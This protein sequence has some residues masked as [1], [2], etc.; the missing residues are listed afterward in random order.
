MEQLAVADAE[1]FAFVV[2]GL[3]CSNFAPDGEVFVGGFVA[4][5]V[6]Q[7][8]AV[9]FQF[10]GISSWHDI[11]QEAAVQGLVQCC[12]LSCRG[13]GPPGDVLRATSSLM[14]CVSG[15]KLA[16]TRVQA[17][18]ARRDQQAIIAQRFARY[19]YLAHV[20]QRGRTAEIGFAQVTSVA[21]RGEEP[22]EF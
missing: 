18:G 16:A 14:R 8:D 4:F 20:I 22:E 21:R 9:G 3:P 15:T 10:R 5:V 11:E 17:G 19:R 2:D 7:E 13:P 12:G 6:L 1:V